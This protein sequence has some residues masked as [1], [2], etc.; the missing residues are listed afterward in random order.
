MKVT[1]PILPLEGIFNSLIEKRKPGIGSIQRKNGAD[2]GEDQT[3][4]TTG[5]PRR[6]TFGHID[7]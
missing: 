4:R 5:D 1:C 2:L 7:V 6:D 3:S